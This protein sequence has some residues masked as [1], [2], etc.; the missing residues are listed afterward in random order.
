MASNITRYFAFLLAFSLYV[1]ACYIPEPEDLQPVIKTP[2]KLIPK[3]ELSEQWLWNDING[4]SYLTMMRNQFIPRYCGSCWSFGS[5][6]ALADRIKI[7]R[8]AQWPDYELAPQ[9]LLSCAQRSLGCSG[10]SSG[11]A[12]EYIY[13]YNISHE[14]CSN[15]QARGWKNGLNCSAEVKCETCDAHGVCRVPDDYP[16]FGIEEYGHI[17]G[18]AA[19][20][21][22][23]YQRGP[24]ACAMDSKPL[25][26]YTG[27]IF[28][29]STGG[30]IL[31]HVISIVG[32]GVENG[33][34]FW[35]VRNTHGSFWG[36][37]GFFRIIRGTN[38]L[39]IEKTCWWAV[40]R[41]TWSHHDRNTSNNTSPKEEKI[42]SRVLV[43]EKR[44][45]GEEQHHYMI[46]HKHVE[47][48]DSW[49][50]RNVSGRNYMTWTRNQ[51][52]KTSCASGWAQAATSALADRINIARNSTFP[53][54]ALSVQA[55]INC[56]V[57]SC[58]AG[59]P[60]AVHEFAESHGIPEDSCQNYLAADP[61]AAACDPL[62]VCKICA[63]PSPP[64][65]E[66]WP[67]NCTAITT[68][69]N[70]K[71]S[72]HGRVSGVD[73]M[74]AAILNEGPIAC[75]IKVTD[76]FD[77]YNGGIFSEL[78][79]PSSPDHVVSVVGW[80]VGPDGNQYWIG[81]NSKGISW[82]EQGFFRILM[83]INNLGI[84]KNCVW[85]TPIV[86][87]E[88]SEIYKKPRIEYIDL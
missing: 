35:L 10:G 71:I 4:T 66:D 18:E 78:V 45:L 75:W 56:G 55:L 42:E 39:G 28:N 67:Q 21:N 76:K 40:P 69:R 48:P 64:P 37:K 88:D 32:Y 26:N 79:L 20:M 72:A 54:L 53:P 17:V 7:M 23:I 61:P 58:E 65:G 1:Q 16:I 63:G 70:W 3:N 57:G 44:F 5:T 62:Q 36:E 77:N 2:L 87:P 50:W 8:N 27:G 73:Q 33:V 43:D 52:G 82:G 19:M 68:Y 85:A 14:S 41:D 46:T 12:Y 47:F 51:G 6:S 15:Y 25:A 9:I 29:S 38:N 34:P 24:I 74:K 84:E 80:G 30:E 22:E 83:G 81:R 13:N 49:D 86:N 59:D 11:V 31:N 60:L